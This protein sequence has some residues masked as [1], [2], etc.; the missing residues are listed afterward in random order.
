M[1]EAERLEK[2]AERAI[3]ELNADAAAAPVS[4]ERWAQL[5]DIAVAHLPLIA[6]YLAVGAAIASFLPRAVAWPGSVL[7]IGLMLALLAASAFRFRN[8]DARV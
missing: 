6:I 4:D 2:P 8:R 3:G 1:I 5:R 7:L